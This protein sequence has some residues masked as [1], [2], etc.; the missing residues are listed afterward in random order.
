[1]FFFTRGYI[2]FFN[3]NTTP[4][5]EAKINGEVQVAI[6]H[7]HIMGCYVVNWNAGLQICSTLIVAGVTLTQNDVRERGEKKK[8]ERRKDLET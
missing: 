8:K 2:F 4:Y 6:A 3:K 5:L 1:M 7:A